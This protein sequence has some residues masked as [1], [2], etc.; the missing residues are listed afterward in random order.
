MENWIEG[1]FHVPC[2]ESDFSDAGVL[3][4]FLRGA[5]HLKVM[6]I[7]DISFLTAAPIEK[8]NLAAMRKHRKKLAEIAGMECALRIETLS[9]YTKQKML[10]EGIPF[11]LGDKELYLPFLGIVLNNK[12]NE[13]MPPERISFLTQKMLLTILYKGVSNATVTE[14]AKI[15][16]IS[17]M[18]VTRC[19]DELE[20]FRLGVIEDNGKA[21]RH[22]RWSKTKQELWETVRPLL[23]NPVKKEYLLDCEPP[24]LLPKSG[25]TAISYFSML[26]DNSFGTYAVTRQE[27]KEMQPENLPQVPPGELP[28]AVIQVMGYICLCE[29]TDEPVIDPL[30]AVLSLSRGD[31]NDPR[32]EGAV[33]EI[34]EE[35]VNGRT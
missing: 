22:F 16:E 10:E 18:S 32:M 4:I 29:D 3:P 2:K 14:M 19:F 25:V 20:S 8:I 27:I 24:C 34:M 28:V 23:R 21:G 6:Q 35:F 15:L 9:A 11:I 31:L 12:K 33:K 5:Y 17:K 13:K 7:A 26:A 1:L 30:S